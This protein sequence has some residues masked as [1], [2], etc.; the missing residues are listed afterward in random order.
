MGLLQ[1]GAAEGGGGSVMENS[2]ADAP[3][4]GQHCLHGHRHAEV[5]MAPPPPEFLMGCCHLY[6][7]IIYLRSSLFTLSAADDYV[8]N[9]V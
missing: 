7:H 4:V 2:G 8:G 5:R 1:G 9:I 6:L 3:A